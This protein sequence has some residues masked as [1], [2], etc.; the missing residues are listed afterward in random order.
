ML[1]WVAA[2]CAETDADPPRPL[3][4]DAIA[5]ADTAPA[6]DAAGDAFGMAPD[7]A[8]PEDAAPEDAAPDAAPDPL[9]CPPSEALVGLEERRSP[10]KQAAAAR[11]IVEQLSALDGIAQ[12][13]LPPLDVVRSG[14][15]PRELARDGSFR[16]VKAELQQLGVDPRRVPG[17]VL[18][19]EPAD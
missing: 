14:R 18:P 13:R 8:A 10:E 9:G 6:L 2:A 4:F 1:V 16:D 17:D 7:D 12:E 15:E 19:D 11:Y 3:D 5:A